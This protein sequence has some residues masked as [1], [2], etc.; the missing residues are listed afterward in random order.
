[1]ASFASVQ[2]RSANATLVPWSV[3]CLDLSKTLEELFR[4]IKSGK[5][6]IVKT[7]PELSLAVLQSVCV[8]KDRSSQSLVQ[9]EL[10]AVDLC[11][12]FGL[13][14]RFIVSLDEPETSAEDISRNASAIMMQ[15]LCCSLHTS[16]ISPRCSCRAEQEGQ[17]FDDLLR[18]VEQKGLKLSSRQLESCRSYLAF[19]DHCCQIRHYSFCVKKCGSRECD[20][21]EPVQM[22]SERFKEIHFLPDPMNGPNDHYVPFADA[23]GTSTTEN[24]H[25][26]LIQQRKIKTLTY[27][28][29]EQHA[30]KTGALVQCDEC[31]KW[32]LLFSK[33]KLTARQ[34]NELEGIIADVSYSCGATT[35]DLILPDTLKSVAIRSHNCSDPNE[36]IYYSVYKD[37][38]ICIHCGM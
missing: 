14:I 11:T 16:S 36:K 37:D 23:Y 4:S 17:L 32:R 22:D 30:H 27:S 28:P 7:S 21:C 33:R 19:F 29:S 10:N 6:V 9:K 8:G 18:V 13:Y 1:M 2:V 26:S 3:V 31:D 12:A 25:P 20:I 5:F 35:D 24:D 34:R 38:P 15:N